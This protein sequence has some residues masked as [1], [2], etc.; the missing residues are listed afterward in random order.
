MHTQPASV[1]LGFQREPD[2]LANVVKGDF[3]MRKSKERSFMEA[4]LLQWEKY[5][6]CTLPCREAKSLQPNPTLPHIIKQKHPVSEKQNREVLLC[7]SCVIP[8]NIIIVI[9]SCHTTCLAAGTFFFSPDPRYKNSL[10]SLW[11]GG[12]GR[13]LEEGF[14]YQSS[15]SV[16]RMRAGYWGGG[17]NSSHWHASLG[18]HKT[19]LELKE[20]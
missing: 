12:R 6:A 8:L 15:L 17:F 2:F 14:Y 20:Q 16:I 10:I 7:D 19:Y 1:Q 3:V 13:S 9:I 4:Y 5:S 18:R 11:K